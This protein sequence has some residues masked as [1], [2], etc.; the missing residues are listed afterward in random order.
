MNRILHE[1]KTKSMQN[2]VILD[3][4]QFFK[5]LEEILEA[6][7][8]KA[9]MQMQE[10]EQLPELLTRM[11]TAEFLS[12]SLGTIDNLSKAGILKKHFLGRS[13]RFKRD[14]VRTAFDSWKKYQHV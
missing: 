8:P 7:L 12:V 14:E 13:P 10:G 6:K 5:R 2:L 11:E 9:S 1:I 4:E 3:P